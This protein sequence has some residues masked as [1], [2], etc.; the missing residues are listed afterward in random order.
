MDELS[1]FFNANSALL[2][3]WGAL[4][5]H[6]VLPIPHTAHPVTLWHKFAELLAQ[7]VNTP[8]SYQQNLISGT[9]AWLLMVIPTI[10]LC[11]ALKPLVWHPHLFELALL[12]LALDW[13]SCEKFTQ[14]MS[15][16]LSNEDKKLARRLLIPFVNRE[17]DTLSLLGLG[18]AS[19]ETLIMRLGRHLI[20]VLFWYA[21]LGGTG[22]FIYRLMVELARCWSPSRSQF[23]PFGLPIIRMVAVLD[24][25]PLRGFA[26]LILM[27]KQAKPILQVTLMQS[28]SWPLP[29]PGWLLCAVG[30]KLQLSLG[31]PA[32]YGQQKAIRAK[33]GGRIAPASLHL[34]QVYRLLSHRVWIWIALQS[35]LLLIIHQGF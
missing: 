10:L 21:I 3:M 33:I 15:E 20:G 23:H 11:I 35:L 27:G 5:F 8:S 32:I 34:Q 19:V 31:G 13:R 2:I 4:L 24:F 30:N 28:R 16:A 9:L 17:T 18:K 14:Q 22:A 25:I 12:L 6:W 29:G 7:K 1:T 26:L